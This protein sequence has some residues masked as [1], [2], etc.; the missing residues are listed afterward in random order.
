MNEQWKCMLDILYPRHCALCHEILTA[1]GAFLSSGRKR[2]LICPSCRG[3]AVRAAEPKC[4]KCGKP[5]KDA[6]QEYCMDC[7][8]R[9]PAFDEGAGIFLYDDTM[10]ASVAWF[11]YRGRAEYAEYFGRELYRGGA[12]LLERWQPEL[13]IPVPIHRARMAQRG[14][15]QAGLLA[16]E[17]FA[18]SGIPVSHTAVRRRK[19]TAALKR[20]TPEERRRSMHRAFTAKKGLALPKRILII[21]DIYT[22][23]STVNAL[24]RLLRK[25]G[26]ER[27]YFLTLCI[28]AGEKI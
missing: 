4:K 27:V 5:L 13:L 26:A 17:L 19:S 3:K 16:D 24:A 9:P 11:K 10:R 2:P 7:K 21:D 8:K 25:H 18:L 12:R 28:G 20:Q 15:N 1:K 6:Q 23:G 14:Y 22:T